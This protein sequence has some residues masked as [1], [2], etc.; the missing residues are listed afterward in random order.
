MY[1]MRNYKI[2]LLVLSLFVYAGCNSGDRDGTPEVKLYPVKGKV[3]LNGKEP[4]YRIGLALHATEADETG[5]KRTVG[6]TTGKGGLFEAKAP[7]G[8]FKVTFELIGTPISFKTETKTRDHLGKKYSNPEKS[9]FEVEIKE[10]SGDEVIDLG[11][12]ALEAEPDPAEME[13]FPPVKVQ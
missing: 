10:P 3:L 6:G 9:Q 5:K 4:E 8:K 1:Q 7:V 2:C 13:K 11:E 12:F